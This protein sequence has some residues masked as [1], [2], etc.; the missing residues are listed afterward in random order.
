MSEPRRL[1]TGDARHVYRP[2][3]AK[4][5]ASVAQTPPAGR[6]ISTAQAAGMPA[7][8]AAP[9]PQTADPYTARPAAAPQAVDPYAARPAAGSYDAARRDAQVQA[10]ARARGGVYARA[11]DGQNHT[12]GRQPRC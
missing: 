3:E 6:S 4:P 1:Y 11:A 12:S 2:E 10:N 8:P 5:A 7:A 9:A